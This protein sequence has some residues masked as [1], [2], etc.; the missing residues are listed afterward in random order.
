MAGGAPDS[1]E[2]G[3]RL[4]ELEQFLVQLRLVFV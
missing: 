2:C 3:G 1:V 4:C